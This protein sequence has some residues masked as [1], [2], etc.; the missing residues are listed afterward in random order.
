[1]VAIRGPGASGNC[2]VLT[3]PESDR[4]TLIGQLY[5]LAGTIWLAELLTDLEIDETVRLQVA[6]SIR[7]VLPKAGD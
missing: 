7:L 3:R 1:M 6:E 5:V 2:E 4:A